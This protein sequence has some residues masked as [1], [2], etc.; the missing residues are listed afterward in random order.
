MKLRELLGEA[1]IVAV[2]KS[3]RIRW[4]GHVWRSEGLLGHNKMET[5]YKKDPEGDPDNGGLIESR[6]T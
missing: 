4:T 2:M 6:I 3:S 5:K 1:D